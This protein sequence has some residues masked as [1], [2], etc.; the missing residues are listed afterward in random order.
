[1]PPV[2]KTCLGAS[3][4]LQRRW[5]LLRVML[6]DVMPKF[7]LLLLVIL[8]LLLLE[9]LVAFK[10][11]M[12][13]GILLVLQLMVPLGWLT[14]MKGRLEE[15]CGSSS[16]M[17]SSQCCC[18]SSRCICCSCCRSS[19]TSNGGFGGGV[20]SGVCKVCLFLLMQLL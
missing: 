13:L 12:R 6:L 7:L 15:F 5:V 2:A 14:T 1:M 8:L 10:L 16:C 19:S 3:G 4:V 9:V 20:W 17:R 18:R 11:R